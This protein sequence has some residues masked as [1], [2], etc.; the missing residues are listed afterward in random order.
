MTTPQPPPL[1]YNLGMIYPKQSVAV[2]VNVLR[3]K[4]GAKLSKN[5]PEM[6]VEIAGR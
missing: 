4:Y 1:S 3:L 5:P 6:V 2:C